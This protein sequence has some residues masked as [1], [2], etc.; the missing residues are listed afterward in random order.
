MTSPV[1]PLFIDHS[2]LATLSEAL[3]I[4]AGQLVS[5]QSSS[6]QFWS[7]PARDAIS[8]VQETLEITLTSPRLV[9]R[10]SFD[11]A[12]FPH[13]TQVQYLDDSG[14]WVSV[15]DAASGAPAGVS[16]TYS[17]PPKLPKAT[18]IPGHLHPQ[19]SYAGHWEQV[20]LT[21]RPITLQH[22]RLVLQRDPHGGIPLD[23]FNQPVA[24][25]LAVANLVMGYKITSRADIPRTAPAAD[26]FTVRQSFATT[27]DLLG[28]SV[29]YALRT[30]SAT[31]IINN[32]ESQSSLIWRCEPQPIPQAVVSF[33]ADVRD[34]LG[35]GQIVDRIF[36]DPINNGAHVNLYYSNDVPVGG[37]SSPSDP[38]DGTRATP[39]GT[40]KIVGDALRLGVY[41]ESAAVVIDNLAV[42]FDPTLPWWIGIRCRPG[43]DQG[44]DTVEHPLFDSGPVRL[45]LTD[46]GVS[47]FLPNQ[48][49]DLD[50][51]Y[52]GGQDLTLLVSYDTSSFHLH[53]RS[54]VDDQ[55]ADV[56]VITPIV[57]S[58]SV[59]TLGSDLANDAYGNVDMVDFVLKE[60]LLPSEDFLLAPDV[61]S[62]ANTDLLENDQPATTTISPVEDF[63][64]IPSAYAQVALFENDDA[65]RDALLRLD[66][67][68]SLVGPAF[69]T[70]LFGGPGNKYEQMIWTPIPRG[71][72]MQRG[73]M[74]LPATKARYWKLEIT[75]LQ[76][77]YRDIYLPTAQLVKTF[78]PE[79]VAAYRQL[80]A[81]RD[82]GGVTDD[83]GL[84]TMATQTSATPFIDFP[85]YV[86][87]GGTDNGF[88]NTE[89]Y[90][91]DDATTAD[92]LYRS[93]GW[94]WGYQALNSP[95]T[96]PRWTLAQRHVYRT[97][98][99]S[100]T[101]K[102][103]YMAGL[104][105]IEFARTVF[106]GSEDSAQYEDMFLDQLNVASSNW[107]YD[108]ARESLYSGQSDGKAV[109]TSVVFGST[110][111]V[112]GIQFAAQQSEPAQLLPDPDFAD[113]QHRNWSFVG[114]AQPVPSTV[115]PLVGTVLPVTRAITVGY[116]GDIAPL[117]PTYGDLAATTYGALVNNVR[118]GQS[119]GGIIS[120]PVSQPPGGRVY[121]AARVVA[122]ADLAT[123][124]WVQIVDSVT[125]NVLAES[126]AVVKRDQVTEW[127]TG[128][129]LGEGG[130][131]HQ[132][133]YGDLSGPPTTPWPVFS[134][135]FSRPNGTSLGT[136]DSGQTWTAGAAGS[137][138][139]ASGKAA[140]SVLG[141]SDTIDTATLWGTLNV[142][143][144]NAITAATQAASVPLLD[145][146]THYFYND[147]HLASKATNSVISSLFTPAAGD[148]LRFDFLPTKA[149][150]VSLLPAGYDPN[151]Q[152]YALVIYRNNN[153]VAT[154]LT[155]RQ[156]PTVRG[157]LGA[158]GQTFTLFGWTPSYAQLP[159]GGKRVDHMPMPT[160]GL[161]GA[162]NASWTASDGSVWAVAGAYT[163]SQGLSYQGSV[164]RA[165]PTDTG[166]TSV[167]HDFGAMYGSFVFN[168]VQLAATVD[169]TTYMVALLDTNT[170]TYVS[171]YLRA[172]GDVV[173]IDGQGTVVV[174]K[175]NAVPSPAGGTIA[176][177][178]VNTNQLS[179]AFKTTYSIGG[180]AT[181]A[182]I[183]V[184]NNSVLAVISGIGIWVNTWRGIVSYND[185][186]GH[187]T[188]HE[189]MAWANDAALVAIDTRHRT[190]ADVSH[191]GTYT[192]GDL[193]K[194]VL[195]NTDQLQVRVLQKAA[196]GDTWLQ[197]TVSL[198]YD[199]VLWE[200]SR[201]GGL[202]WAPAL[203]IRNNAQGVLIF[204]PSPSGGNTNPPQNQLMWRVT[205]YSGGSWVSHLV[206]RPWYQGLM[207]G[208]PARGASSQQGP[209][210]NP[211]DHY[212]AVEDDP[213]FK[214]WDKPVPRSWFFVY[215]D[216]THVSD[217]TTQWVTL[218]VGDD[219]VLPE[220]P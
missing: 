88:T 194:T 45:S 215:R 158:V 43:Y 72:I 129:T 54:T 90:V 174:I 5:Q 152:S 114:D 143:L 18:A 15:I 136:M 12:R 160:D 91:A 171:T 64:D 147:G 188:I 133:T 52:L 16:I 82:R 119:F 213:R 127:Y 74:F 115:I 179:T 199:P 192:Y 145:L 122:A 217:I 47:L 154:H 84:L 219:L 134:D 123:P 159:I 131:T 168:V 33:Y 150:Q 70:G 89:V 196:S 176:V 103:S 180:T 185:G 209:N 195:A 38:L 65:S 190:W 22:L 34:A 140:V 48:Q 85:I 148:K 97:E 11:L 156:F 69:P 112:R 60:Q 94:N 141:Q 55:S 218:D 68:N 32:T 121:A 157:L 62:T 41:G 183:F 191:Q 83:L 105:R 130:T 14:N 35:Q 124:L 173:Q 61:Y 162:D 13:S 98:L 81:D 212:P 66:P 117:Y 63:L 200:F 178:Y 137:L 181:Q 36:L 203:D 101:N 75:N 17:V 187:F 182:M 21:L 172:N 214:V 24:Y 71:Y 37:F 111:N 4:N 99:I 46:T 169:P 1:S 92:R 9:N 166:A 86:S 20:T 25:S 155:V 6:Q 120:S 59:L 220:V 49:V 126:S 204:P 186:A 118:Q 197:D 87:T 95:S 210:V 167:T 107:V 50:V 165:Q 80:L 198:Y 102:L 211:Y 67:T 78:P 206:I 58:S 116:W 31:N 26:S 39:I 44:V 109:A 77:E 100:S 57:G 27:D 76:P 93:R 7:T 138:T 10:I 132:N 135:T 108:V 110:R 208:I 53:V 79:V 128:Y 23:A 3:G 149:V 40:T 201:D 205:S 125:S 56:D 29:D 207:R 144:G 96:A 8:P 142:T 113:P 151:I 184:Q 153:W 104:R 175:T 202:S 28:S 170:T 146:G 139:I 42:G 193:A 2:D 164:N 73:W 30:N 177:R 216:L 161:L 51:A 19:H 106:T 189:G 163:F